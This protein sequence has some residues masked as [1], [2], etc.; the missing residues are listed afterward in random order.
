[1]PEV[2]KMTI[3]FE[4]LKVSKM[5][6]LNLY[7][8][9]HQEFRNIKFGKQVNF[10]QRVLFGTLPKEVLTSLSHIHVILTN[11]LI[12]SHRGYCYQIWAVKTTP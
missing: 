4:M 5:T 10:I 3:N 11:L 2:R 9:S 6:S 7:I 1:M 12:S 8:S